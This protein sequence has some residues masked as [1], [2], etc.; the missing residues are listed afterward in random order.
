MVLFQNIGYTHAEWSFRNR[1]GQWSS[2]G[3]LHW[4]QDATGKPIRICYPTV[5]L[6]RGRVFLCGVTDIVEPNPQWLDY[7]R[8][9][10]GREWDYVFRRLYFTWCDDISTGE[11][12]TWVEIAHRET[13]AGALFPNDLMVHSS[14][15]VALLWSDTAI[16]ERLRDSFFSQG[17]TKTK[18]RICIGSGW[19]SV[20]PPESHCSRRRSAGTR[21]RPWAVSCH[22]RGSTIRAQLRV[23]AR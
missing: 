9:L 11:F 8:K 2:A 20:T 10:T 13:T 15:D 5:A 22:A 21:S 3:Q 4:P 16:D 17:K 1:S 18:S 7:K 23:G 6:D 19:P 12:H 14:G